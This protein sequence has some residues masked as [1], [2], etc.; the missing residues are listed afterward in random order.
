[1]K[2]LLL[3]FLMYAPLYGM[4]LSSEQQKAEDACLEARLSKILPADQVIYFDENNPRLLNGHL[5]FHNPLNVYLANYYTVAIYYEPNFVRIFKSN[6]AESMQKN[7]NLKLSSGF[8]EIRVS[9]EKFIQ[10]ISR[11]RNKSKT[12]D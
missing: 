7:P 8:D 11:L 6:D 9:H 4:Q 5:R 1:M 12:V 2:A 10:I 3:A